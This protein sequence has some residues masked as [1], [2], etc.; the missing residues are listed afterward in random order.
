VTT[1]LTQPPATAPAPTRWNRPIRVLAA[2]VAVLVLTVGVL[3]VIGFFMIRTSTRTTF[4]TDPVNR[5]QVAGS[6][7]NVVV[8]VGSAA[9][10]ATVVSR[11]KSAFR[12]AEHTET[13]VGGVLQ[14]TGSCT[15][16]LLVSDDCS[17]DFE[18]TV[19]PGTAV[20]AHASTGNLS[21]FD[22]GAPV[23]A[24]SNTGNIRVSGVG[25]TVRL[26]SNVGDISGVALTGGTVSAQSNTGDVRLTFTAA[27]ARLR[28]TT[29]VGDVR[30]MV[31]DDATRYRVSADVSVGER[32]IDVATDPASTRIVQL[33]T[34]TG[35][36]RMGVVNR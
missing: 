27:P 24:R 8:R 26:R 35:D 32:H 36:I 31:P 20:D 33:S 21:V 34:D 4:F 9:R 22:T 10:G 6:T 19:P 16:G 29:N 1:Q 25:G 11:S 5:L 7:G 28:A 2:V 23:T 3:T 18:I 14:V 15:G 30:I 17:V 12:T 13:V